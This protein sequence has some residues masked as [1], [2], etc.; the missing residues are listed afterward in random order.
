M[1]LA[2]PATLTSEVGRE[3]GPVIAARISFLGDDSYPTGGS[4]NFAAFVGAALGVGS[5]L[6]IL[7]VIPQNNSN[8][9]L[10]YDATND[11][12]I[13]LVASTGVEVANTT[14]LSGTT[15]EALVI[16]K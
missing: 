13:A 9:D 7:A 2:T 6:Q 1:P 8:N 16:A 11:T 12:L 3:G 10:R 15:F 5:N 14:D 4:I